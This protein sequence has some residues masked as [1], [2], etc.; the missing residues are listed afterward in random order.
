MRISPQQL[1]LVESLYREQKQAALR[2]ASNE[3]GRA[4]MDK[5]T[6]SEESQEI[7]GILSELKAVP[8]IREQKVAELRAAVRQGTYQVPARKVAEKLLDQIAKDDL[9]RG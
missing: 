5:V 7:Q 3:G 8:E 6:I 1:K 2:R 4:P 9:L